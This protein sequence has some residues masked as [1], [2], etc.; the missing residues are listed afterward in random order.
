MPRMQAITVRLPASL[1]AMAQ[2]RA[3]ARELS[4]SEYVRRCIQRDVAQEPDAQGNPFTGLAPYAGDMPVD[5]S[6]NLDHYLKPRSRISATR[7]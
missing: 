2:R 1:K 4:L 6:T 7:R 5:G 3:A